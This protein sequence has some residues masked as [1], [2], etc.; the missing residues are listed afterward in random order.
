MAPRLPGDGAPLA[1]H[2]RLTQVNY[3]YCSLHTRPSLGPG[4]VRVDTVRN[5]RSQT[6]RANGLS[7]TTTVRLQAGGAGG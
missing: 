5:V 2:V 4:N 1:P 6:S 7:L 3:L